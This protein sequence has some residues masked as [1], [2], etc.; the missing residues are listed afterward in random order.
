MEQSPL[1]RKSSSSKIEDST[2][3]E[4]MEE[5]LYE[6]MWLDPSPVKSNK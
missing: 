5:A 2:L 1:K 6:S 4:D 3:R